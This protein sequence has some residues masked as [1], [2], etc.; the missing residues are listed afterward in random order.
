[1]KKSPLLRWADPTGHEQLDELDVSDNQIGVLQCVM[2][3]HTQG[4]GPMC[5]E[6]CEPCNVTVQLLTIS[7][8]QL[9]KCG[10]H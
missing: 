7:G 1:M 9:G 4:I 2:P 5:P 3:L 10:S 6:R 8:T